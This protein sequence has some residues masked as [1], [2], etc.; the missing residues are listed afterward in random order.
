MKAN[1]VDP[2]SAKRI[3]EKEA[4]QGSALDII[5]LSSRLHEPI[6]ACYVASYAISQGHDIQVIT[7]RSAN[8]SIEEI[9]KGDPD[10][11][12]FSSLTYD[13]P[14][15][16]EAARKIKIIDNS[17]ITII[18]GYHA[19]CMP[20]ETSSE[21]AFDYAVAREADWTLSDLMEYLEQKREKDRIR[22]IVYED[23]NIFVENFQ[24]FDPDLNPFPFRTKDMIQGTRRYGLYYPAPSDQKSIILLVGSRGCDYGCKFCLSSEMFPADKAGTRTRF[25][26]I[27]N[28]IQEISHCQEKFG[29]NYG[30][31]VDL[32]FY[33][34]D[35]GRVKE[36]C[37]EISKTGFRWYAMS[38]IDVDPEILE[39]MQHGGCTE[40]GF[41]V[42]SLTKPLKAG[43]AGTQDDWQRL[44]KE[45]VTIMD[46]LGML[47]KGYFI[48]SDYT[49]SRESIEQEKQA[50]L[51]S[52]F[53]EIR[54]SF[55]TYSPNTPI[56]RRLQKEGRLVSSDLRDF[57]TDYPV[58]K[59]DGIT[60]E[61]MLAIRKDIYR[62]Y[63][64]SASY[65]SMASRKK[66]AR[67]ELE[68]SYS[69][70]NELLRSTLGEG[71][72]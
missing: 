72:T 41:G 1:I 67:P 50:I 61:G 3:V 2:G 71:F 68:K 11:V 5:G 47:S 7:P 46:D 10:V 14:I 38:R 40:I 43:F 59:V 15:A 34:G 64:T 48:I 13:Y 20:C 27:D 8:L 49:D 57:S 19:T 39:H 23:G 31:F 17:I 66:M 21:P 22:G 45:K 30:F 56:F 29:T 16:L 4:N 35:K 24:R 44:V 28:I 12:A 54:I 18:G 42:E 69:E 33:G 53:D 52:G 60:P 36:L 51:E 9:L 37:A 25:R 26:D 58:V 55:M 65:K 6:G 32:N 70:F 62:D 63:Y